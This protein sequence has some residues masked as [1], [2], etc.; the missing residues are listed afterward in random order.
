MVAST[1]SALHVCPLPASA[2][3]VSWTLTSVLSSERTLFHSL[4]FTS[5]SLASPS[6][7]HVD[8]SAQYS[9]KIVHSLSQSS[10]NS[11][12]SKVRSMFRRCQGHDVR[13]WSTSR[14]LPRSRALLSPVATS[15]C[16]R[17]C[18]SCFYHVC[19]LILNI[20]WNTT[21]LMC[22]LQTIA[23][24]AMHNYGLATMIGIS[25]VLN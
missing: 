6:S 4:V 10:L 14:T 25:L 9:S 13:C 20:Q 22:P 12:N 11:V 15:W 7:L 19:Y 1:T 8:P 18:H 3:L 24:P 2:P 21:L 23:K 17:I 5:S 16:R